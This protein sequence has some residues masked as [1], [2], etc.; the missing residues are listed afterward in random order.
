MNGTVLAERTTL[1]VPPS[2]TWETV[3]RT[4][5]EAVLDPV[6]VEG[7][8]SMPLQVSLFPNANMLPSQCVKAAISNMVVDAFVLGY[9]HVVLTLS[10]PVY[11]CA[12]LVPLG[13]PS[14]LQEGRRR[15]SAC[16]VEADGSARRGCQKAAQAH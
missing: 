12:R 10:P 3:V 1:P 9:P 4:R 16:G 2:A 8:M 11:G 14:M 5:L 15:S 7:Y 13:V 6:E